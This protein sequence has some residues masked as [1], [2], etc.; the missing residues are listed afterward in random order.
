MLTIFNN[1]FWNSCVCL[2]H[3]FCYFSFEE[4]S[5]QFFTPTLLYL[6]LFCIF[7]GRILSMMWISR[8]L[9]IVDQAQLKNKFFKFI[10]FFCNYTLIVRSRSYCFKCVCQIHFHKLLPP[11]PYLFNILDPSDLR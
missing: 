11:F 4:L 7:E 3:L 5:P 2:F 6:V 1:I 10:F 8:N 9:H